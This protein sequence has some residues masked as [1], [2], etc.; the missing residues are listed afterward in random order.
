MLNPLKIHPPIDSC[1]VCSGPKCFQGLCFNSG[2][3]PDMEEVEMFNP[4]SE[5]DDISAA[6]GCFKCGNPYGAPVYLANSSQPVGCNACVS[7]PSRE[8]KENDLRKY[9]ERFVK[10]V[11]LPMK[12]EAEK[13]KNE[14]L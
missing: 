12:Q 13:R 14:G 11:I 8:K 7:D 6:K 4:Y 2:N 9:M 1:P 3:R 10:E 5:T